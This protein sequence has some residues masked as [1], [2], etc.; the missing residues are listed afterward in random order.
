VNT[1][2]ANESLLFAWEPAHT[3]RFVIFAFL[4]ASVVGH[5]I[6]FYLFQIV[7]P[8]T[9][10]LLPPPARVNVISEETEEGRTLLRWM[11]AEDP[12]LAT[13]TQRPA[14]AKAF[15]VPK[16]P[17]VPSYLTIQPALKTLPDPALQWQSS[18]SQ[19]PGPVPMERVPKPVPLPAT[20]TEIVFSENLDSLGKV[21]MPALKF[22]ASSREPP[23]NASFRVAVT[24]NGTVRYC[25]LQNS[26]GD[27]AL[28]EQARVYLGLCR[29]VPKTTASIKDRDRLSW[30]SARIGWGNDV[31]APPSAPSSVLP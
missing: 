12:A 3:R 29:F 30:A 13:T 19:P 26:S 2:A 31:L 1:P 17:H 24:P 7:Y 22:T 9:V 14:E 4:A 20:P 6:C 16:L 23:Q 11:A 28:D 10:A 21:E 8:P 27:S 5:A 25:F 18:S 15:I